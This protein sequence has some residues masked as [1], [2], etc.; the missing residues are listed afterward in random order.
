MINEESVCERERERG[1]GRENGDNLFNN[2]YMKS[3]LKKRLRC[4]KEK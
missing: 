4:Y 2:R 3:V 1:R